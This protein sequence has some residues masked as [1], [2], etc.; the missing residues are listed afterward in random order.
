MS[1][2]VNNF[3]R[4]FSDNGSGDKDFTNQETRL[5][6]AQQ[7]LKDAAEGLTKAAGILSDMIRNRA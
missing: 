3:R 1:S 7:Y 6:E 2:I 5:R 4:I